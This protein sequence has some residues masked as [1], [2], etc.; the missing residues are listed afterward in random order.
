MSKRK[1]IETGLAK[2]RV[3]KPIRGGHSRV[4]DPKKFSDEWSR[5]FKK[6]KQR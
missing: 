4:S 3:I 2:A 1:P 5:I 6:P